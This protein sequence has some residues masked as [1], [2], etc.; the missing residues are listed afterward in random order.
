MLRRPPA[1]KVNRCYDPGSS[2]SGLHES[3]APRHL[4]VRRYA[5]P[6]GGGCIFNFDALRAAGPPIICITKNKL[7][8][9][10]KPNL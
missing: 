10:R 3:V 4:G 8:K 2:V 5:P 6:C 9:I 7:L 1:L